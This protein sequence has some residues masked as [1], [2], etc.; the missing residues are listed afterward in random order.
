MIKKYFLKNSRTAL[1]SYFIV[2]KSFFFFF[3]L[4]I[5]KLLLKGILKYHFLKNK[6]D[7]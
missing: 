5:H 7:N 1:L 4:K 2:L 3:G 6:T